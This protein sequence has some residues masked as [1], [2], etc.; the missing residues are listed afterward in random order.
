MRMRS[1]PD[2]RI[3]SLETAEGDMNILDHLDE[4]RKRLI[5]CAAAVVLFSI[6]AYWKS[7]EIANLIKGPLGDIELV[8]ITPVEGFMTNLKIAL[9]GG[10]V[11]ASPIVFLQTMLFISPALYKRERIILFSMLPMAVALFLGGVYFSFRVILPI[12]LSYLMSFGTEFMRPMLS[13]GAYFSFAIMFI[14]GLGL[15]FEFPMVMLLLSKF[16]VVSYKKLAKRRKYII[17]IIV[18]ISAVITPP[19][20]ISQVGIAGPLILLF[21]ISL[22]FMF[23]FDKLSARRK[24]RLGAGTL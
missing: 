14:T 13:A 9:F 17:L 12:T 16:G 2:E 1:K 10:L 24:K 8:Y 6:A 22:L 15:V 11:G 7:T 20:V 5:I 19:D 3:D 4:L 23:I 18:V 21:E